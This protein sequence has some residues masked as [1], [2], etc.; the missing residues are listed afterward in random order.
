MT[1]QSIHEAANLLV[2]ARRTSVLL[3]GL[4]ASCRPAD[5]DEAL[6]IQDATVDALHET[7]AGWKVGSPLNGKTVRGTIVQSRVIPSGGTIRA[8]LV[9]LL[10]VEAEIAF[11]F[12]R[13]LEP[14][15]RPYSYDEIAAAVTAFPAIEIVDSRFR[16][17]KSAPLIERIADCVSN[18][19]FV[20][21]APQPRWREFDLKKIEARLEIDGDVLVR[22]AG[23]HPAGDPLLPAV[24]LVNAM[25]LHGGVRAGQVVTTGSYTGLNY[26]KPGQTISAGFEGF[27]S[28]AVHF[29]A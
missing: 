17:Y 7:V 8:A 29:L 6:A 16:D 20:Q 27:G 28:A 2:Q 5:V 4:P 11:R 9:P 3:D 18:G 22:R 26:A 1:P 25:R 12:D 14:R 15:D 23:G 13:D 21:G 19:A 24:E 10:G